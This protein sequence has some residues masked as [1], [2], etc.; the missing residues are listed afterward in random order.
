MGSN[1]IGDASLVP[2]L[3][4]EKGRGGTVR[5]PVKRPS[6]NLGDLSVG[7]TPTRATDA[8]ASASTYLDGEMDIMPRFERGVP[9]SNPG[10][11]A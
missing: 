7:S 3:S 1:P 2:L 8:G 9:G 4:G 11:G 10:R 6:S 5:K